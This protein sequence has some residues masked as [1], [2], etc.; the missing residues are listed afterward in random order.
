MDALTLFGLFAVTAIFYALED[1][2]HW[3]VLAFAA[4]CVW[5][6]LWLLT[7]RMA[8]RSGRKPFGSSSLSIEWWIKSENPATEEQNV[9]GNCS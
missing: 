1:R 2:S 3:Y 9:L 8:L 6:D 4:A 7:R 5:L